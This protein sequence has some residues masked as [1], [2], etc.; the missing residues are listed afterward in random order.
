MKIVLEKKD[1][2]LKA[3]ADKERKSGEIEFDEEKI[4]LED[5]LKTMKEL[6]Y[7]ATPK[8]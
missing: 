8:N 1:G 7:K 4:K 6:R 5:I 3:Y 2:V